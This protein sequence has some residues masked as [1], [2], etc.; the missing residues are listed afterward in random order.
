M[1]RRLD[2]HDEDADPLAGERRCPAWIGG[3]VLAAIALA[4]YWVWAAAH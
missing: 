3:L 1:R 4:V 2:W